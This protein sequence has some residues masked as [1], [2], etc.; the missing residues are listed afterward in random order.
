[1]VLWEWVDV[2]DLPD[3]DFG[4]KR[5]C[6]DQGAFREWVGETEVDRDETR[7]WDG[8]WDGGKSRNGGEG[9]KTRVKTVPQDVKHSLEMGKNTRDHHHAYSGIS[10]RRKRTW[11]N[12][13]S[14]LDQDVSYL[15]CATPSLDLVD[16]WVYIEKDVSQHLAVLIFIFMSGCPRTSLPQRNAP[17]LEEEGYGR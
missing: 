4:V 5:Q 14:H 16:S 8:K 1:M 17:F 10:W 2:S 12:N 6:V 15:I 13:I 3:P 7:G 11:M 9:G